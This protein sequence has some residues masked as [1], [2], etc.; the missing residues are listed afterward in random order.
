MTDD[1][2]TVEPRTDD[3]DTYRIAL[4]V[5]CEAR[6]VDEH[7]ASAGAQIALNRLIYEHKDP[8]AQEHVGSA[9]PP[10]CATCGVNT[11]MT[12]DGLVGDHVSCERWSPRSSS[13]TTPALPLQK[14]APAPGSRHS[15]P[16]APVIGFV[17]PDGLPIFIRVHDVMEAS[18]ALGNGYLWTRPTI[19]AFR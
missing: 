15:R 1:A 9:M 11:P 16:R 17:R 10:T 18:M 13:S 5:F 6:G 12:D 14:R 2:H 4:V 7:D 19:R 3:L 8:D